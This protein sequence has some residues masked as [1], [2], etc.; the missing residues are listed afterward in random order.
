M[1]GAIGDRCLSRPNAV[2]TLA[3]SWPLCVANCVVPGL[4]VKLRGDG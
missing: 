1:V 4:D 3:G 2:P